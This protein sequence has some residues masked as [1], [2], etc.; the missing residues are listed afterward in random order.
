MT[1]PPPASGPQRPGAAGRPGEAGAPVR[2]GVIR[3]RGPVQ[4]H[5]EILA[6][7][8]EGAYFALTLSAPLIPERFR[9][10]HFAAVA[11]GAADSSMLLRRAF[12]IYRVSR[13]GAHGGTL[14]LIIG[15]HGRGTQWLVRQ[16]RG[17]V[18]DVIAPLGRPFTLPRD[19]A[20]TVLVGGG[21]GAAPL[22]GLAQRLAERGCRVD[23]VLGAG[24][25]DTLFGVLQARRIAS[26]LT[27][28]TEDGST[29]TRGRVTDVLPDLLDRTDADVVYSCG[30]MPMLRA[31]TDLAVARGA[32][33]QTAVEEAMACGVGVCMTCVLPV[34]G[35]DGVT[36]M[37][38]SCTTGPVF[39]GSRVRWD[40]VGSVPED[41]HGAAVPT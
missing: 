40:D 20:A 23:I 24:T 3:D 2:G 26:T 19:P 5:A 12:S 41:T 28:T 32:H 33:S 38:R 6:V 9:A 29:G 36:R 31:V 34:V 21:Y 1:G 35:N 15:A 11:V 17:T 4:F 27:V 30:P 37:T 16:P 25:T 14:E 8:R 10:G 39:D 18:L 7:R 22:F 13:E